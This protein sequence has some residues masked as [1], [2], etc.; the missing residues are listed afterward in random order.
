[1]P[2][3]WAS[4]RMIGVDSSKSRAFPAGTPS[5]ISV[6]TTSASPRSTIRCAVVEP[7]N[8]PPTTVTFLRM[9]KYLLYEFDDDRKIFQ[10]PQSS[11]R[12]RALR[13]TM[14]SRP[15]NALHACRG[16][17]RRHARLHVLDNR[18]REFRC[19]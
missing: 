7:T 10:G 13:I 4:E 12:P 9:Y 11:S 3:A 2:C 5:R 1:M 14:A 18:R 8:P 17:T 16:L 6:M 15:D 19:P